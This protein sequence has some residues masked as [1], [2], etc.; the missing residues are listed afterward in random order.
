MI[1]VTGGTALMT[2]T[3]DYV[4]LMTY[5]VYYITLVTYTVQTTA[6]MT[7]TV[8]TAALM[9]YTTEFTLSWTRICPGD[10]PPPQETLPS[11]TLSTDCGTT[12]Y[13]N[14]KPRTIYTLTSLF[15]SRGLRKQI[16]FQTGISSARPW[17]K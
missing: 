4:A 11:S 14:P 15:M 12:T 3:V 9:T 5:T 13:S 16:E 17:V 1:A 2:Y 7:Y 10:A 6:L 8:Q